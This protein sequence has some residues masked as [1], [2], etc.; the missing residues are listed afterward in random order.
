MISDIYFGFPSVLIIEYV[1]FEKDKEKVIV[2][3]ILLSGCVV[4]VIKAAPIRYLI[5][6][7]Y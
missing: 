6:R 2:F 3:K 7:L 4:V 1:R 5:L